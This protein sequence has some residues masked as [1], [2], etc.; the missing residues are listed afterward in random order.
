MKNILYEIQFNLHKYSPIY[1][2]GIIYRKLKR[3]FRYLPVIWKSEDFDYRYATDLFKMKLE[4]I[5]TFL[6]S[7]R[8]TS[9]ESKHYASRIRIILRLMVKV[10]D[11]EYSMRYLDQMETLYGDGVN[12]W[13]MISI[14]SDKELYQLKYKWES[15]ENAEEIRLKQRQLWLDGIKKQKRAHK[16]LWEL[17]EHNIQ[18]FWD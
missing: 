12:D 18:K 4:D 13:E 5:A 11:E 9:V 2:G 7:D 6:E 1:Y 14:N 3:V 15:W 16:L 8:A 17:V 10:Y